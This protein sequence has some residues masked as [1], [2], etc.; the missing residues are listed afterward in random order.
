M[1]EST[2]SDAEF[3]KHIRRIYSKVPENE[4]ERII[5]AIND[6]F[7]KTQESRYSIE[8]FLTDIAKII[9]RRFGFQKVAI[10]L[11]D[12]DG[13]FRLK[14][15]VG[16]TRSAEEAQ[17]KIPYTYDEMVGQNSWPGIEI[18]KQCEFTME[19]VS[20]EERK[21]Y[22]RPSLLGKGRTSLEEFREG[23]CIE[24]Y[25][26][27]G[28]REETIGWI[29][30]YNSKDAKLPDRFTIKWIEL[31]ASILGRIIWERHY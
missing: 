11:K 12:P 26:C 23:D 9:S 10:G 15:F 29:E 25:M 24:I 4:I 30:L 18:G 13:M 1:E 22:N 28:S 2:V 31:I 14:G 17:R 27:M 20:E 5:D 3:A 6:L 8:P 16:F 21:T 19:R 7:T